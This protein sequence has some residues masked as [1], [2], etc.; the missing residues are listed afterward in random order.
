[1]GFEEFVDYAIDLGCNFDHTNDDESAIVYAFESE[2]FD[3][4]KKLASTGTRLT[5]GYS[6]GYQIQTIVCGICMW[7]YISQGEGY[8]FRL[9]R[10]VTSEVFQ[11]MN[12]YLDILIVNG[13]DFGYKSR[14]VD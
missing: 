13:F 8:P 4:F 10:L 2:N 12:S 9:P 14:D 7:G 1:M 3:I 5:F 6:C 11:K